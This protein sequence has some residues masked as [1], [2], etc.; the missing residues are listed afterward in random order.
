MDT[1]T[2]TFVIPVYNEETRLSKTFKALL[3][4]ISFAGIK[5]EKIIFVDDGSIDNTL[6]QIKK[7]KSQIQKKTKAGIKII[8]YKGNKGKGYAVKKGMLASNSAYTLLFDADMS[9]PI[10]EFKKFLPYMRKNVPVIIGTRKNGES[11]VI[12]P[13]PLYRQ[14]LG[15]GFT[16]LSNLILN[17][18]VTDFTCGF[19]AFSKIAKNE[20]FSYSRIKRWGYDSEIIFLAT[21]MGLEIKEKAVK[22]SDV[23]KSKVNVFHDVFGSFKELIEIR[24]NDY[25]GTYDRIKVFKSLISLRDVSFQTKR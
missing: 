15:R 12:R 3:K 9:T 22:W 4:G 25:K 19:K 5:L 18:K 20:I 23:K 16:L 1:K 11:T 8:S 7:H 10:T 14:L 6:E 13:Q 21:K 17:T 24:I 2:L